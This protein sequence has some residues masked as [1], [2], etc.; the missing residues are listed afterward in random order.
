MPLERGIV[1][2]ELEVE[3]LSIL[4]ECCILPNRSVIIN[5]EWR[6]GSEEWRVKVPLLGLGKRI[7]D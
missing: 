4:K 5:W 7:M 2:V 1:K 6:M 3:S